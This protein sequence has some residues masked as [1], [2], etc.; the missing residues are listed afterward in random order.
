[1]TTEPEIRTAALG[2]VELREGGSGIGQLT[3]YAAVFNR[4]SQNLGGFVEMVDP[5]AFTKSLADQVPVMVRGN[6]DDAHLLGT[7]WAGTLK[8]EVDGTGLRYTV[9]LPDTSSGRDWKAL[10]ARGD[11]KWSSFAFRTIDDEWS[12]TEQGFPLRTLRAVQLVDVAPVNSPAY[13]D[14]TVAV[15]SFEAHQEAD[16]TPEG[17]PL[18][19]DAKDGQRATHP[20]LDVRAMLLELDA[21]Q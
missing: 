17:E 15:R 3:G 10:A 12:A 19:Q 2:P 1:M 8:L 9:D 14:T 13:L 16:K 7:T 5:G 11:V 4:H 21:Q 6:H 18:G 20:A